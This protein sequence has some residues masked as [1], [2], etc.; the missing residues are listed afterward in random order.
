MR[1]N[2]K[3]TNYLLLKAKSVK[4]IEIYLIQNYIKMILIKIIVVS[5]KNKI[6]FMLL[7]IIYEIRNYCF[8]QL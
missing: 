3:K 7:L 8:K 2:K 5:L 1:I 6:R 4:N